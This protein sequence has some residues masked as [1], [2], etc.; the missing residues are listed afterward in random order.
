MADP[1]TPELQEASSAAIASVGFFVQNA[2]VFNT[3]TSESKQAADKAGNIVSLFRQFLGESVGERLSKLTEEV[4]Q[5]PVIDNQPTLSAMKQRG[6][7]MAKLAL[8]LPLLLNEEARTYFASFLKGLLGIESLERIKTVLKIAGVAL[9][10][11]FAAKVLMQVADTIKTFIRLARLTALLFGLTQATTNIA[12]KERKKYDKKRENDKKNRE[13]RRNN[14][15]KKIERIRKIKSIIST[16]KKGLLIGGPIGIAAGLVSG[17][18]INS[19]I[20]YIINDD[21]K[22][23]KIEDDA[24]ESAGPDGEVIIPDISEDIDTSELTKIIL[25]NAIKELTFGILSAETFRNTARVIRGDEK[26]IQQNRAAISGLPGTMGAEMD[27][28]APMQ[29]Q[30]PAPTTSEPKKGI[31]QRM[32]GGGDSKPSSQTPPAAAP[33]TPAPTMPTPTMPTPSPS[34]VPGSSSSTN[35]SALSTASESVISD[36]KDLQTGSNTNVVIDNSMVVVNPESKSTPTSTTS[37]SLSVG[38]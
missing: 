5:Q 16:V 35:G 25:D 26:T 14:R 18:V 21:E 37:H 38:R 33:S 17:I 30:S 11:V 12:E 2:E 7:D 9:A 6:F 19:L 8:L 1:Q 13:T 15:R 4:K 31:L 29:V 32:F 27:A 22:S 10:T 20:D 24:E 3:I 23:S 36:R 34:I 28:I